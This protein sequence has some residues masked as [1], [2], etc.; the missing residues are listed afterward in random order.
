MDY[1]C[2][3][4]GRLNINMTNKKIQERRKRLGYVSAHLVKKI[5][6]ASTQDYLVVRHE[7]KV[8]PKKSTVV[9]FTRLPYPMYVINFNKETFSVDLPEDTHSG[10]KR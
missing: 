2:L 6:E 8:M 1:P 5:F 7:R 3:G 9:R 10:K 4:T